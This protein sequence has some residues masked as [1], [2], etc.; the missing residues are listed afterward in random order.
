MSA[1]DVACWNLNLAPSGALPPT[2][3]VVPARDSLAPI[4]SC[5]PQAFLETTIASNG[6]EKE[7][8]TTGGGLEEQLCRLEDVAL[9]LLQVC[10]CAM[11][12][13]LTLCCAALRC[14][15]LFL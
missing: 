3:M 5:A 2:R 13:R 15:A 12:S 7:G 1:C 4:S 14:V 9:V 10:C 8:P 11:P 6:A